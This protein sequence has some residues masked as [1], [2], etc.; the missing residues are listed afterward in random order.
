MLPGKDKTAA[1]TMPLPEAI[2]VSSF[3]ENKEA[4]ME[5]VKWYSSPETQKALYTANGSIPTRNSVLEALI[6]D[7]T[8]TNPGAMLDMAKLIKSPFPNGVPDYYAEM[9]NTIFN[10]INR[11]VLGEQT[12]EEAFAAMNEKVNELA[13]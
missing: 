2:G 12:P 3:S 7:G 6:E 10:N 1:Q 9:S 11:M 5:F 4:A 13:K 8:I